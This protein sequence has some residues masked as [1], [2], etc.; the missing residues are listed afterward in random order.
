MLG[1]GS[2]NG[3]LI[4]REKCRLNDNLE[5]KKERKKKNL[6]SRRICCSNGQLRE[7]I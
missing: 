2:T 4:P 3:S 5:K 1:F 6:S 7:K